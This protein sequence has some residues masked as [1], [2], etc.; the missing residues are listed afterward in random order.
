VKFE[1]KISK[2]LSVISILRPNDVFT[3]NSI[4]RTTAPINSVTCKLKYDYRI[5]H[6]IV[7]MKL[8]LT[9]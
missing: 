6:C 3:L 8:N 7:F 4:L 5:R 1:T 2:S 9:D